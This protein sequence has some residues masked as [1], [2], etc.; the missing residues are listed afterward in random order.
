MIRVTHHGNFCVP[1]CKRE[2]VVGDKW[3]SAR[4]R[5]QPMRYE[6]GRPEPNPTA[7]DIYAAWALVGAF[8]FG[9]VLLSFA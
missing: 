4:K 5:V 3:L 9:L 6:C 7:R 1:E 2:N 8:L